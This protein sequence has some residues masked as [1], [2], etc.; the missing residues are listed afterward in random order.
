MNDASRAQG[1]GICTG[2]ALLAVVFLIGVLNG[3]YWALAIPV[4]IVALFALGLAGWVGYTIATIR[5]E[6][7][8]EVSQPP[9]APEG[10]AHIA[11]GSS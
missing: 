10:P 11:D 6:T 8:P 4:S 9:S 1:W 7:E 2:A 5:V 3:S